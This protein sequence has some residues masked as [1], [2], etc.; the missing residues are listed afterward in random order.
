MTTLIPDPQ[1]HGNNSFVFRF[2]DFQLL[3][4]I[5]VFAMWA[6][7]E[8]HEEDQHSEVPLNLLFLAFFIYLF[9]NRTQ[10]HSPLQTV[11]PQG[12]FIV[13]TFVFMLSFL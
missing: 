6:K 11:K 4:I 2:L 9:F 5:F 3:A 7:R 10:V 1:I 13:Q 12:S 8:K